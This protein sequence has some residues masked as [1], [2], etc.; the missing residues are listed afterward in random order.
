LGISREGGAFGFFIAMRR[1]C[2]LWGVSVR[3]EVVRGFALFEGKTGRSNGE[4]E[5]GDGGREEGGALGDGPAR[6]ERELIA[7]H[8]KT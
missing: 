8:I 5:S 6:A 3:K 4:G 2:A 7:C 1:Q